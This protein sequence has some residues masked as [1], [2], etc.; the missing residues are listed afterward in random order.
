MSASLH[1][2]C[3]LMITMN[4]L[5]EVGAVHED[6][7]SERGLAHPEHGLH[8]GMEGVQVLPDALPG[9][10]VAVVPRPRVV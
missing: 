8:G 1:K 5:P 6:H 10:H 9:R 2:Y 3:V 7:V 4:K